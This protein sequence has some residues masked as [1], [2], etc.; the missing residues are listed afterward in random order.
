MVPEGLPAES[1]EE[2]GSSIYRICITMLS[3]DGPADTRAAAAAAE[4]VEQFAQP[5]AEPDRL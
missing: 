1:V 5:A 2:P 4:A 3:W